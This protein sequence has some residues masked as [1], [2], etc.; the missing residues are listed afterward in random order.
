MITG[1]KDCKILACQF[2]GVCVRLAPCAHGFAPTSIE[3][4]LA[5][6]EAELAR[7]RSEL[8]AKQ[9]P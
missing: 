1:H 5:A 7:L 3:E 6:I 2:Y 4:W 8:S 9:G